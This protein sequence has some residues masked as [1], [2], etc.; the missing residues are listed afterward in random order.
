MIVPCAQ[1][2]AGRPDSTVAR[3]QGG[4]PVQFPLKLGVTLACA[5]AFV[6]C[7]NVKVKK[8]SVEKRLS[9]HDN[10]VRGFRYYLNRPY[11]VV[12]QQIK[13]AST[14]VAVTPT[15]LKS[16]FALDGNPNNVWVLV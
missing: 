15:K 10:H 16:Q 13:L 12:P 3:A 4:Q 14:Y 5:L 8:V 1:R 2:N 11:I 9:G 7:A 6:G